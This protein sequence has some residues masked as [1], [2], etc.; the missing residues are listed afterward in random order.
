MPDADVGAAP[1]RVRHARHPASAQRRAAG[2]ADA[3]ERRVHR[4]SPGKVVNVADRQLGR[5]ALHRGVVP[6]AAVRYRDVARPRR[7][8][9]AHQEAR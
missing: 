2:I 5:L 1:C 8:L 6:D 7:K 9:R 4:R 3:R